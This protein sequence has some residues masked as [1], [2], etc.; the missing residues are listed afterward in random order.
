MLDKGNRLCGYL[1]EWD[2]LAKQ[3]KKKNSCSR[4]SFGGGWFNRAEKQLRTEI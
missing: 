2:R 4:A 1:I 3:S